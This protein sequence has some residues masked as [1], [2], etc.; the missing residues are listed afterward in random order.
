MYRILCCKRKKTQNYHTGHDKP[1][2]EQQYTNYS[3]L[4]E[5]QK[6]DLTEVI[7]SHGTVPLIK[8]Y[9][10]QRHKLL[11]NTSAIQAAR[12]DYTLASLKMIGVDPSGSACDR[13]LSFFRMRDDVSF[14]AVSHTTESGYVTMKKSARDLNTTECHSKETSC[15]H[16]DEILSWR[17]ALRIDDGK[18]ILVAVAWCHDS[19]LRN[20]KMFPEVLSVDVTFGVC[21]EQRNLLRFCGVDGNFKIFEAMNCFMPSK[22]VKAYEWAVS[23]AFPQLAQTNALQFNSIITSDQEENLVRSI[24]TLMKKD[25]SHAVGCSYARHRLDMYHIFIKEWRSKVNHLYIPTLS[26]QIIVKCNKLV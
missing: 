23:V 2:A 21:R 16:H 17:N 9:M 15:I 11:L 22:Q 6:K 26:Y 20:I 5:E 13:L 19:N 1:V 10:Y 4:N 18:R 3:N 24:E 14:I 7:T 8:S 12:N 25:D